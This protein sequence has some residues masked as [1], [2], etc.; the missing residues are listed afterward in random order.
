MLLFILQIVMAVGQEKGTGEVFDFEGKTKLFSYSYTR[1]QGETATFTS[2][3]KDATTGEVAATEKAEIKNGVIVK[4]EVARP[5]AKDSGVIETKDSKLVFSYNDNG[6]KSES[7][8]P[9]KDN[10]LISATLIPHVEKHFA[11]LLAKK[12]IDF[13]YAVWYRKETV[14]FRFSYDRDEGGNVVFKMNPTNFLYKS[15]VKP[16]YFTFNKTSK[17]IISIQ[18]RTLPKRKDGSSWKDFDALLKYN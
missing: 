10:T 2:E 5:P 15:L 3:Y 18:G 12:D 6:K 16:I 4:Y 13:R 8:E 14:G 17:K 7:K 1:T 11:D 9:L